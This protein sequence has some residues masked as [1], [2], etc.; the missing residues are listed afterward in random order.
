[1]FKIYG[2]IAVATATL[3]YVS[4]AN[5]CH[6][7]RGK[8]QTVQVQAF[9]CQQSMSIPTVEVAPP[10]YYSSPAFTAASARQGGSCPVNRDVSVI[11]FQNR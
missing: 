5:A 11:F 4:E 2:I 6:R 1:M 9:G 8:S 10:T 3:F 7:I